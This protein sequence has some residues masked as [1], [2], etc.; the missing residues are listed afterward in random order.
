M[1]ADQRPPRCDLTPGPLREL[2]ANRPLPQDCMVTSQV[3]TRV[4]SPKNNDPSL[5][6]K[7]G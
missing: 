7:V 5:I 1:S 2:P 6:E 3:S 4:N